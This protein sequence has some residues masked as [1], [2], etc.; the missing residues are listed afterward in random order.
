MN[1]SVKMGFTYDVIQLSPEGKIVSHQKVNNIMINEGLSLFLQGLFLKKSPP[2]NFF[3][4]FIETDY[5]P[6]S[7][8]T[9][10]TSA[11]ANYGI[12]KTLWDNY[13][14]NSSQITN[15]LLTNFSTVSGSNDLIS[16]NEVNY[17]FTEYKTITGACLI[18]DISPT[19]ITGSTTWKH[20]LTRAYLI[21]AAL[22]YTPVQIVPN[23]TLKLRLNFSLIS[24]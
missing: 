6:L 4:Q 19:T 23:G 3:I 7:T 21:S 12:D 5:Q 2:K 20:L 14:T 24:A 22:F 16:S 15:P 18:F 17:T 9:F 13:V 8:D 1:E 11:E 10:K